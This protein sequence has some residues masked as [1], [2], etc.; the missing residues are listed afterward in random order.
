[1]TSMDAAANKSASARMA[2]AA[3]VERTL[4]DLGESGANDAER[5][6]ECP[7]RERTA[8]PL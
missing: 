4:I 1:M 5:P 6:S 8:E 7:I 2:T 3:P